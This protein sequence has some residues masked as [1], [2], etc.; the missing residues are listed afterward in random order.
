MECSRG[1]SCSPDDADAASAFYRR[2]FGLTAQAVE[3][4]GRPWVSLHAGRGTNADAVAGVV[5]KLSAETPNHW[6]VYFACAD[7]D[8]TARRA[9]RGRAG[10]VGAVR[11]CA[12]ADRADGGHHGSGR[13][14]FQSLRFGH[15]ERLTNTVSPRNQPQ[16][17]RAVHRCH[18]YAVRELTAGGLL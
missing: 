1:S 10:W 7:I 9:A 15:D 14:T 13:S 12:H 18:W 2:V 17:R 8:D 16:H 4:A 5:G 6:N 3:L 11:C